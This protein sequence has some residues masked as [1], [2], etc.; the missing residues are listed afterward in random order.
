MSPIA[1]WS[2]SARTVTIVT[3]EAALPLPVDR[4]LCIADHLD[5]AHHLMAGRGTISL[6]DSAGNWLRLAVAD[7]PDLAADIRDAF[8]IPARVAALRAEL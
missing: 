8:A 6:S 1:V 3:C 4:I 2:P 5:C 7:L